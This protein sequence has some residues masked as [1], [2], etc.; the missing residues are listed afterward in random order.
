VVH[1]WAND[2]VTA[3]YPPAFLNLSLRSPTRTLVQ[4]LQIALCSPVLKELLFGAGVS[5]PHSQ[6]TDH[7][8][9]K[10]RPSRAEH[11]A[12]GGFCRKGSLCS[13]TEH[14]VRRVIP[15]SAQ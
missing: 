2:G 9:Y 6:G 8:W 14:L 7:Q 1:L 5:P 10:R 13:V 3:A 12:Q 4:A 11:E 15:K